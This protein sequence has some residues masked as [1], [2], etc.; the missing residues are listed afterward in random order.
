MTPG[1][2]VTPPRILGLGV[3]VVDHVFT[4][5]RHPEPDTKNEATSSHLRGG[6]P[7]PVALAQLRRF[8][9]EAAF[10]S[11]WGGDPF[12]LFIEQWLSDEG[13][14]F[15]RGCR[16]GNV[17]GVS[18]VW[19][20]EDSGLR[21]SVTSRPVSDGLE[22]LIEERWLGQFEILHLD[23][24]A[25]PAA[26]RAARAVKSRGGL[27]CVDTGSPKPG[28]EELLRLADVVNC[29]MTFCERVFSIT[30]AIAASR[31]IAALG[32]RI[33]TVTRGENGA[34]LRQGTDVWVGEALPLERI[35]DTNGA[36]D[37]FSAGLIHA[38]FRQF[39]PDQMLCFAIATAGLKCGMA[40]ADRLVVNEQLVLDSLPHVTVQRD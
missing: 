16:Q 32:P 38:A 37:I 13:I 14:S 1:N 26:L 4:L 10:V 18:Q 29:P 36:G 30:D 23:G 24:W 25:S 6:G 9:W 7:V 31:E 34:I 33:V 22:L 28:I 11:R 5:P 39:P 20:E 27:V 40:T 2:S 12:G 17:T 3:V 35:I 8:G 21:T 15:P 19:L